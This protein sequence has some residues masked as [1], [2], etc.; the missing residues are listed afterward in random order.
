MTF[1]DMAFSLLEVFLGPIRI[2]ARLFRLL[3]VDSD[4]TTSSVPPISMN[5]SERYDQPRPRAAISFKKY[6]TNSGQRSRA[7]LGSVNAVVGDLKASAS[8]RK[9]GMAS[10]EAAEPE[11]PFCGRLAVQGVVELRV[12]SAWN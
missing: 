1:I 2:H 9:L 5:P 11:P 4:N 8:V 3:L 10:I 7:M 6:Q 12:A